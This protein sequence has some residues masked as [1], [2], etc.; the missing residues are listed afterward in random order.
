MPNPVNIDEVVVA[1]HPDQ[2]LTGTQMSLFEERHLNHG[3]VEYLIAYGCIVQV[4]ENPTQDDRIDIFVPASLGMQ[5]ALD[6]GFNIAK[7]LPIDGHIILDFEVKTDFDVKT[8]PDLTD[9]G[10]YLLATGYIH[11]DDWPTD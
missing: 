9:M 2:K 11:S 4:V 6:L 7:S 10:Q 3:I 5:V 8:G 1:A